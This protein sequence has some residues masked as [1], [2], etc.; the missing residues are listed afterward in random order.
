MQSFVRHKFDIVVKWFTKKS[1][2]LFRL[3]DKNPHPA[4]KICEDSCSKNYISE[5]KR[6]VETR[7]NEHQNPHKDSEQVKHLRYFPGRKLDWKILLTVP[8]YKITVKLRKIL[9]PRQN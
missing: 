8:N 5:I 2:S 9:L 3:K 7:W 1:R 4:C 6:N